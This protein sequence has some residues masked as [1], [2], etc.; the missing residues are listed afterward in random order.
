MQ[1]TSDNVGSVPVIYAFRKIYTFT[2]KIYATVIPQSI[3]RITHYAIPQI[4]NIPTNV[5]CSSQY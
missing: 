5:L 3:L 2:Q 1:L 4:I